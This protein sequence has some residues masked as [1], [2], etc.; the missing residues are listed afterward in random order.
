MLTVDWGPVSSWFVAAGT[1]AAAMVALLGGIG[2][3]GWFRRPRLEITFQ[4]TEPW[5]RQT[6]LATGKK[7]YWV[8]IRVEN[9]GLDP[10]R[11]CIGKLTAVH[12]DGQLR[13]D[14]DPVQLRWC[15]VHRQLAFEPIDLGRGQHEFLNVFLETED[16]PTLIIVTFPYPDFDPGFPLELAPNAEHRVEVSVFANNANPVRRTLTLTFAG[17][18]N[19]LDVR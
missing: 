12:T 1:L 3:W 2:I 5:C 6:E 11:G 7:G 4:Q 8:R 10:A 14:I 15:G 16:G 9:K 13:S 19:T 17:T 18:F